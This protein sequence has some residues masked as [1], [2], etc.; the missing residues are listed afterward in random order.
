MTH[1]SKTKAQLIA[2]LAKLNRKVA[3][4]EAFGK[5]HKKNIA[6]RDQKEDLFY[7]LTEDSPFP[8]II[9]APDGKTEYINPKFTELFGYGIK[10]ISSRSV[11]RKKAYPDP[12]YRKQVVQEIAASEASGRLKI[13]GAERRIT[14]ADG[15]GVE[16]LLYSLYLPDGRYYII[17]AVIS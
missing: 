14:C 4:L 17:I 5:K 9:Y 15:S 3:K 10:D 1:K 11:W 16:G 12:Q 2:E 6:D 7:R 8:A 13:E